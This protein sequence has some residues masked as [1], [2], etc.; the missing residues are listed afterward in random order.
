MFYYLV[1][2]GLGDAVEFH[3][4]GFVYQVEQGWEGIAQTD[5]TPTGMTNVKDPFEFRIQRL[6][7]AKIRILPGNRVPDRR[8]QA[9]F[10]GPLSRFSCH[11]KNEAGS[12]SRLVSLLMRINLAV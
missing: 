12:K 3:T 9:S 5:A 6:P 7:I 1:V 4:L 10:S 8:I 11:R 2:I